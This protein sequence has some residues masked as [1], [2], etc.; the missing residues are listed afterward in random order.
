MMMIIQLARDE[1]FE[2][3]FEIWLQGINESFHTENI[4]INL[5]KKSFHNNFLK[6]RGIFNYWVALNLDNKILGWQSLN[7]TT[8][9]PLKE[10]YFA[11][12]STYIDKNVR[13]SDIGSL[14]LDHV[15]REAEKSQLHYI[16]AFIAEKNHPVR[17][18]ASNLGCTEIGKLPYSKKIENNINKLLVIKA[19]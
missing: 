5:I 17:K 9:N 6:R 11:E 14:L 8:A 4:D 1:D 16:I 18:I 13:N 15:F 2:D 19:L 12:S 10:E 3:I 7:K